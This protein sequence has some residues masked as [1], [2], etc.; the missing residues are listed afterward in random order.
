M[1]DFV[2]VREFALEYPQKKTFLG[3][4][5]FRLTQAY[6][7]LAER[8]LAEQRRY[9]APQLRAVGAVLSHPA[10]PLWPMKTRS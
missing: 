9:L 10:P 7:G 8:Y 3:G 4:D 5:G 6:R 2:P 1:T